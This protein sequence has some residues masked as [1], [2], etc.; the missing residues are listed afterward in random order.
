MDTI[1]EQWVWWYHNNGFS[2][3]PLGK[4]K[5]FWGNNE[6]ELKRPSLKSWD[7]YKNTLATKEEIDEWIKNDLFQGIA[8]ICGKVSNNLVVIDIDDNTIPNTI[9]LKFDKIIESG[10]WVVETG[11]GFHIYCRHHSNPGGI[12]KPIRYKIEYRANNGYV[13]APPS[14]HPNGKQYQFMNIEKP[15]ELTS[16]VEKDVKSIFN[17]FKLQIGKAWNIEET[18]HII[19][20][21]TLKEES[22]GY[23]KCVEIA[24][25]KITKHPMRY[26]TIYGITSS[27]AMKKIP[28]DMAM[29]KLK[30]FNMEKCV[31][32]HEN[33]IIEQAVNGAYE[34]N[35]HHYGCEFWMDHAETCP[36]E[37]IMECYYGNK[38]AKR[39][40]AR[41]YKIFNYKEIKNKE[42]ET[43]YIKSGVNPP[44]LAE[45]ILNE[46]DFNFLTTK[47]NKQIFYYNDG[48]Y[49][50]EGETK[51][52]SIAEE[53]MEEQTK[54]HYKNEIE[55]YIRDKNYVNREIF[56]TSP[57]YVNVKNGIINLKTKELLPH[58]PKHYFLNEIP[59]NYKPD[60]TPPKIKKFFQEITYK[61]DLLT[62]QEFIGY[63]LYRK[64]HIHK[65]CMFLGGGKNGKSTAINL[66]T[67]FLG[68]ENVSN[69]E[70]QELIYQR[71]AS[72][73]L[74][75]KLL[76][77]AAD[78]SDKALSKTGKFKELTGEDRIDA[79][80]KFKDSFSF[81]NYAKFL[82]SANKLPPANDDSYAFYR[83]WI[84]ISFPNTFT[85]KK[86]NPDLLEELTTE[87]ELSGLLNWA[88]EGLQR[89]LKN[90]D[91]SYNK[92]VE[93]VAEQ[94]K[95]LSDPE[96]GF[97]QEF[98]EESTGYLPKNEVYN[99]YKEWC[100]KNKLPI[101]PSNS[102]TIKIKKHIKDFDT[103]RHMINGK[104]TTTYDNISWKTTKK[105]EKEVKPCKGVQQ[106]EIT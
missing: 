69:K 99:K 89:L 30:Q 24:L 41:Q 82:F 33:Y 34:P 7:K 55:D 100:K 53:F 80:M 65:A 3:I 102:F 75:G 26:Y 40:L 44:N 77:A 106:K 90:K 20:G 6:D 63:C 23:P 43:I 83:R 36:Y 5:G 51:I 88:I 74:Y 21:T 16:L 71:F 72:S 97:K 29:R 76:N 70:L 2:I 1:L 45:L 103:G 92:T 25:G 37:N 78:I 81:V 27:F 105:S 28:K 35:A 56:I 101:A 14:M 52:R 61:E 22:N 11:N 18:K 67:T 58:T 68:K 98:I 38:K 73:K 59:V 31:P 64:Y 48:I 10:S 50:S 85:G 54:T 104:Q 39:E 15:E 8:V 49:H 91:F 42:G 96:Y 46:Y 95:L 47:D 12:K 84:L 57:I 86:C 79:E 13:V 17:D 4:N 62:L 87:E 66:I 60:I 94:Y 93:E 32:P 9:G 19:K